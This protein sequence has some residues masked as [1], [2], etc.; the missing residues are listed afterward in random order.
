MTSATPAG[1]CEAAAGHCITCSDEA[2]PMR[3]MR[4]GADAAV[5][6]D[7]RGATHEVAVDLLDG[8]TLGASVLVHAGVAIGWAP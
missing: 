1:G 5:C 8:V 3:V 4:L 6:A 2:V 7:G